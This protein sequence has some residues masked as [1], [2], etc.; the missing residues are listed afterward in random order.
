V[1]SAIRHPLAFNR[2]LMPYIN[3]KRANPNHHKLVIPEN[4]VLSVVAQPKLAPEIN[5]WRVKQDAGCD[6]SYN[7]RS[8]L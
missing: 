5:L 6:R 4:C 8:F 1:L 3:S 2:I 7:V